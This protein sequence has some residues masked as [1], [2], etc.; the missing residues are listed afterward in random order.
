MTLDLTQNDQLTHA[1]NS[2]NPPERNAIN[3][4]ERNLDWLQRLEPFLSYVQHADI[5]A[6]KTKEFH[7]RIWEA[8]AVSGVGMGTVDISAA[9]AD[10]GFRE[11]LA[12]E[13]FKP[14]GDSS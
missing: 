10:A 2:I 14:L 7:Q 13:S 4:L 12:E 3:P 6:R 5:E 9:I 8:N 11:W 1:V